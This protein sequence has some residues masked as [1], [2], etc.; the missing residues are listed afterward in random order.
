MSRS[1]TVDEKIVQLAETQSDDLFAEMDSEYVIAWITINDTNINYPVVQG[2]DNGWFLNRNYKGIFATAGSIFLDFRNVKDFS[3]KFSVIYG[4]R[5][6]N[7]E[8]FSD[9]QKFKNEEFFNLHQN[10]I[11]RLRERLLNLEV[12]AYA[13]INDDEWTVYNV[14]K[15]ANE[16]A[17]QAIGEVLNAAIWKRRELKENGRFLLLSTCDGD[18]KNKRDVLLVAILDG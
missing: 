1:A 8:M 2:G 12:A 3:D 11:L 18:V 10:G 5:M 9:I 7:G 16:N 15:S 6:G 17:S 4:H 13:E 14:E